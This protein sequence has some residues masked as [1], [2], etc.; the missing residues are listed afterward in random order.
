MTVLS[1]QSIRR[2]C[3]RTPYDRSDW[4]P[5]L[6]PFIERTPHPSGLTGGLSIAG[7]DVHIKEGGAIEPG[8]FRLAVTVE[9][10]SIPTNIVATVHDKS[11]L[12]RM[13]LAVQ[14][15]VIEPGWSGWLTLELSNHGANVIELM[16]GQPIAQVLFHQLD[17]NTEGYDGRYQNQG[18]HPQPAILLQVDEE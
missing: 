3:R 1:G 4:H 15:T 18:D 12:A 2:L 14:T 8:E 10:F 17:E 9:R 13:G 16:D 5:L 6:S 7:Y 11:T